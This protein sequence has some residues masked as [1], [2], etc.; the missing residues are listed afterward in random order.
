MP[1]S[2]AP[3]PHLFHEQ[4]AKA[5]EDRTLARSFVQRQGTAQDRLH[6]C[7]ASR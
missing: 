6:F 4:G 1:P 5:L 2:S 7:R 3:N